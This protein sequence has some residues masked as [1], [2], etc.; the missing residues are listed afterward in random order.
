[1]ENEQNVEKIGKL[2]NEMGEIEKT[3]KNWKKKILSVK[4]GLKLGS[5]VKLKKK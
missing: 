1:M 4:K 5:I 3:L 2:E